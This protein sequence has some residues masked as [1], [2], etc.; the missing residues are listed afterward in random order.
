M[1][2]YRQQ[3]QNRRLRRNTVE[4]EGEKK[5]QKPKRSVLSDKGASA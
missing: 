1:E 3:T 4:P 5:T 2:N